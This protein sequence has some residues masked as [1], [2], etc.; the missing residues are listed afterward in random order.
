MANLHLVTGYAGEPHIKSADNASLMQ[1]VYGWEDVVFD[2]NSTFSYDIISNNIIRVHDGEA[3]MQGRYIKM[4]KGDYVDLNI[5]NGHT[6]YKRIDVIAIEYSRDD[7]T[8][9][10]EANLVVVKGPE[11]QEEEATVPE[12]ID[13]D[14]VDGSAS[15]NQMALYHVKIDGFSIVDVTKVYTIGQDLQDSSLKGTGAGFHSS[16]YRGKYLGNTYTDKQKQTIASGTFDDLFIGDYWRINGVNWRI[17]DFDYYYGIGDTSP[18]NKHHVVIVP[19][20]SLYNAAMVPTDSHPD[21][22]YRG[23]TNSWMW[24]SSMY[25]ARNEFDEAFGSSF[26][27]PH[28]GLYSS[29]IS[30]DNPSGWFWRDMRVELMSE[31][32]VYGHAIWGATNHNGYDVGTQ[33]TQFRLFALDKTKINIGETYWLTNITSRTKY[34]CVN[35][36]GAAYTD[37]DSSLYGVRPFACIVGEPEQ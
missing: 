35:S 28:E 26:I 8:G 2:R 20:N 37:N 34:A 21:D 12:L 5:D 15:T 29:G 22:A 18:F 27:P 3:L 10:E 32:Q 9:I 6:G 33:T 1:A 36:R 14:T 16:T 11:T 17:A 19:D 24:Q 7:E 25:K 13:G 23:Y 31:E 4:D 30:N